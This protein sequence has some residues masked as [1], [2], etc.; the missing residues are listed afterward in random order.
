MSR[1]TDILTLEEREEL[2]L[3]AL[4][5]ETLAE[6]F[7]NIEHQTE[8]ATLGMWVFLVTEIMFFSPLFLSV[9][10]YRYLYTEGVERGSEK[11]NFLISGINTIVLLVS[12][13]FMVLGV[14]YAKLGRNKL[15]VRY[16]LLTAFMGIVFLGFKGYEYYTD[17]RDNLIPGWRFE[18]AEWTEK[19]AEKSGDHPLAE[20]QV[21]H[22]KLFLI[23]YWVMTGLHAFHVTVGVGVVLVLA[24]LTSRGLFSPEY[25]T[26]VDVGGLY[27]HFVDVVWVFLFPTLYLLSTHSLSDLHF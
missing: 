15:V 19:G 7:E 8:A 27:W 2:E 6:Q 4:H 9:F 25:Y 26:P 12:S 16:L 11:L 24:Y 3:T 14:H 17:Y 18:N 21:P 13:L 22:V 23:L 10:T 5:H 1:E 20:N